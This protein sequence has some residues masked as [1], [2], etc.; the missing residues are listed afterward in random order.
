M[1]F[2]YFDPDIFFLYL[3]DPYWFAQNF[4]SNKKNINGN[5][6]KY[7]FRKNI[8]FTSI[9]IIS[10]PDIIAKAYSFTTSCFLRS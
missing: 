8:K 10:E 9:N 6:V 7:I 1:P 3:F 4:T 2:K 5:I